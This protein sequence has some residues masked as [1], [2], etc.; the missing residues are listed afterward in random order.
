MY[1]VRYVI[2]GVVKEMIINAKNGLEAQ[3]LITNMHGTGAI[4]IIDIRR[5]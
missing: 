5:I 4:Q 3:Q 2:N 1:K